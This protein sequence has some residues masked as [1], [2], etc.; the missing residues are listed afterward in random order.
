MNILIDLIGDLLQNALFDSKKIEIERTVISDELRRALDN[1]IRQLTDFI[2]KELFNYLTYSNRTLGNFENINS[3]S[4]EQMLDFLSRRLSA[5][6]C[7]IIIS[8]KINNK[9]ETLKCLE[10]TFSFLPEI[11]V[12]ENT[13]IKYTPKI[14]HNSKP[15]K[16]NIE[17]RI[18]FP[19]LWE[20][21][22][23][24]RY[25]N[26]SVHKF[27]RYMIK[28]MFEI[29]RRENGL[30]YG[31]SNFGVG[32]GK[33]STTGFSTSTSPENIEKVV[34]LI[35]KT[36]SKIYNE[37]PIT[38]KDL[39]IY[40]HKEQLLNANFLESS[41]MRV[42]TL[43]SH[44]LLYNEIFDFYKNIEMSK[45]ITREDVINNSRGYFEGPMSIITQGADFDS[46][47]ESIW[48]NNFK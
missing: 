28:E 18:L 19:E 36:A 22:L 3:F 1:P 13:E 47:L 38:E 23:E 8:G 14:I 35:A 16:K 46:N 29:I 39:D 30:V 21:S 15:D 24:N 17:L 11:E 45:S 34:S 42:D 27:E 43:L 12:S 25:K 20:S 32:N 48:K 41:N 26:K 9:D 6:N 40:F 10:K 37:N 7:V 4:R 2:S 5:K 31:F 33:F 44:Y